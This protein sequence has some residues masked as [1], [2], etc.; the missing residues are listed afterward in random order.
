[1]CQKLLRNRSAT[2]QIHYRIR[3]YMSLQFI[4]NNDNAR[5][6]KDGHSLFYFLGKLMYSLFKANKEVN[7]CNSVLYI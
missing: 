7:I 3:I 2:K 1:M 4:Y 6:I 5:R